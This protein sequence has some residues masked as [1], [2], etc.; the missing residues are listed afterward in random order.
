M[1]PD[2]KSR[3][4]TIGIC[5]PILDNAP[6]AQQ[7]S[8]RLRENLTLS[9]STGI[10]SGDSILVALRELPDATSTTEKSCRVDDS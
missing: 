9:L 6:G 10:S 8:A 3:A 2:S 5:G 4:V 1:S 7:L